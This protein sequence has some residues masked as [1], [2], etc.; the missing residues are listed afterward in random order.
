MMSLFVTRMSSATAFCPSFILF[1]FF[2]FFFF[3]DWVFFFYLVSFFS[4]CFFFYTH[5]DI[6]SILFVWLRLYDYHTF[7]SF[8]FFSIYLYIYYC[9]FSL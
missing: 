2:F 1:F 8:L 7:L 6:C 5:L 9:S 4:V 3:Y